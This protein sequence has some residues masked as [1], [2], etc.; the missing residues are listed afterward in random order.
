MRRVEYLVGRHDFKTLTA[1]QFMQDNVFVA[2]PE[3]MCDSLASAMTEY[4]FGSVPVVDDQRRVVG[5]VSEFDLL[6]VLLAG[7]DLANVKAGDIMTPNPITVCPTT[8]AMDIIRLLDERH[9]I[10]VL[11][12]DEHGTLKG[13]VARRDV[14]LGFVNA[15]RKSPVF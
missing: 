3:N 9:L 14:L 8:P 12:I 13:V 1:E 2:S 15:T 10:R 7:K 11:V 6:K 5:I 4:G